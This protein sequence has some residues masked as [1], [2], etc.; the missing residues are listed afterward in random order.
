MP[1]ARALYDPATGK[2]W[3]TRL[4]GAGTEVRQGPPGRE[5]TT[6]RDHDDAEAARRWAMREEWSRLRKGMALLDPGAAP[7]EPRLHRHLGGPYTGALAIAPYG[8]GGFVCNRCVEGDEMVRVG[9]DAG[10][11]VGLAMTG[12]RLVWRAAPVPGDGV[13]LLQVDGGVVRWRPGDDTAE[14]VIAYHHNPGFLA[15]GGGRLAGYDGA[16]A[17]VLDLGGGGEV[18]R[19]PVRPELHGGHSLQM[20]GALS[21][22]GRLLALCAR[23]GE[24]A[25]LE[26]ASGRA[27]TTLRGDFAMVRQMDFLPDG[28]RLL[29]TETYGRWSLHCLDIETGRPD[30]GW[31][32]LRI[33]MGAVALSPSGD[34]VAVSRRDRAS[35]HDLDAGGPPRGFVLEHMVKLC[36]MAWLADDALAVRTDLSCASIYA[37]S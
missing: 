6:A 15:V 21:G 5:R 32:E 1:R 34:R 20:E 37:A 23:P 13:V 3:A 19:V 7:G 26:V 35:I 30:P 2:T 10:L 17:V 36:A 22:D 25:I 27:L 14:E 28:R 24:I 12:E 29:I 11:A 16:A 31:T 18:L 8:D 9:P 4:D 33:D